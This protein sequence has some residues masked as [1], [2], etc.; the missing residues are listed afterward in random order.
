LQVLSVLA[1][2]NNKQKHGRSLHWSREN[3]LNGSAGREQL[4][5]KRAGRN[6]LVIG[7]QVV[8]VEAEGTSPLHGSKIQ[9][10]VRV[11]HGS[12]W[13]AT[14]DG[15]VLQDSEIG[16]IIKGSVERRDGNNESGTLNFGV[17]ESVPGKT[18]SVDF[19]G[20]FKILKVDIS[21]GANS[22]LRGVKEGVKKRKNVPIRKTW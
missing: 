1:G 17:G 13:R 3:V 16:L 14:G 12:A 20:G 22:G 6:V 8:S 5:G 4:M 18:D 19:F 10:A 21:T 7:R 15:I 9:L 2:V 11:E